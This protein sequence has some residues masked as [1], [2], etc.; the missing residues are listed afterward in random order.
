MENKKVGGK[1][2]RKSRAKL[3]DPE[4]K[5]QVKPEINVKAESKPELKVNKLPFG[6]VLFAFGHPYY[7]HNAYNLAVSL[8]SFNDGIHITLVKED[9]AYGQL[10]IDQMRIFDNAIDCKEEWITGKNGTDY[11]KAKIHLDEITPY[12]RTLYLDVDMVWNHRKSPSEVFADLD[13]LT[14][15]T[16]NRGRISTIDGELKSRWVSV[17]DLSKY[18]DLSYVY[19]VSSE[20]MYFE[21]TKVFEVAR[22]V[23]EANEMPVGKFGKG[24]PDEVWIAIAI[25]KTNT[26]L[27]ESPYMPTY[28]QPFYFNK[29]HND[30]FML[31]HLATSIGGAFVHP[32]I[33][34]FYSHITQSH[35]DKM[36]IK[37]VPYPALSKAKIP[38]LERKTI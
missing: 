35:F 8:K 32:R 13:G 21:D 37:R 5:V 34:K 7:A 16:A 20:F 28:W 36:R 12:E 29:F 1:T 31:N 6:I 27:H 11:Y 4:I 22:E 25:E 10:D 3:K 18:H 23:Y 30:E 38:L 9:S 17:S 2:P 33:A 14:F 19:D 26:R 15:T 24:L